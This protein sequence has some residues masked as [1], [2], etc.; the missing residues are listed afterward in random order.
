MTI[1]ALSSGPG[2]SGVAVIRISGSE[3]DKVIFSL[4]KR[5]LPVPR[6]A[7]L[8]KF[9]DSKSKELI[10]EGI[11]LW[12]PAPNSYT[13]EDM[14][15]FHVHGSK[16]VIQSIQQN[17]SKV[18]NCR[19]AYPGEFTKIAFQNEKINL[20]KAESIGDLI[21][22]ETEIQRRQAIKIMSGKSFDTFS[23]W[24][25]TLLK[26]LSNIEAK[27][28]FPDEDL[29][30]DILKKVKKDSEKVKVEIEKTLNDS[31]V[32]ERIREGFKI[33]ILGPTN[34]GKSSLLNYFSKREAAIVSEI[35]GTTRDIIEVHLN[36]DGF[37]VVMSDTAGIRHSEDEVEKKGIKLALK[38]AEDA[39]LNIIVFEPK[40]LDFTGFLGDLDLKK[41]L[42]V[43]N[44]LDLGF[45]KI[46][47][48][49]QYNPISISIK[50]GTN[51]NKL[52]SQ[53]KKNLQ[54]KFISVENTLIT[55]ERHRQHL[56]Q[57]VAHLVE[58]SKKNNEKDFDKAAEDVRLATRHLGM[59]V[60]K[61]D[62][63]EILGSI[64]NDFCI[65]K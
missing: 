4:T 33:A 52:T 57:C 60:G 62:V 45:K 16:A 1:Y 48:L 27:I 9:I 36:M 13:G 24:R 65:G 41:S 32:G 11:I 28:D 38:K 47:K 15:E 19:L 5:S 63:E 55:R 12:F 40:S 23:S 64:F 53:I 31:K 39:D 6:V 37:P 25:E 35:A 3:T 7:T 22:S 30:I 56:E 46:K 43:I 44:K 61:V 26:I 59:L 14:A 2:L 51:I 18:K 29:P 17:I 8:S 20:L 58:F 50:N 54:N 49:D 42:F 21:A 10:D 34:A